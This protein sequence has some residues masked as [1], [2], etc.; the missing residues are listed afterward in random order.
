MSGIGPALT[1]FGRTAALW[2]AE[3]VWVGD[4]SRLDLMQVH[5]AARVGRAP[6]SP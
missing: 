1:K 5:N 6:A 4:V 3:K 2:S